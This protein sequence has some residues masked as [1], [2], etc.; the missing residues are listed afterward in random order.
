MRGHYVRR[1]ADTDAGVSAIRVAPATVEASQ[2]RAGAC[3][4][5]RKS[6]TMYIGGGL[7]VLIVI[8]ILLILIF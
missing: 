7:L 6:E 2:T 1:G 4:N 3:A 5:Q 8:I